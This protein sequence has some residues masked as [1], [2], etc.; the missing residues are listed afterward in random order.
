MSTLTRGRGN[1]HGFR[2]GPQGARFV[3]FGVHFRDPGPGPTA[4]SQLDIEPEPV[5][6][7][8]RVHMARWLGKG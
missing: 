4:F 5:D 2:A 1:I 8:R 7:A 6:R 3:D